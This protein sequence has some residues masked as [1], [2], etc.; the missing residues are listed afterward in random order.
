MVGVVGAS[1]LSGMQRLWD[2][3]GWREMVAGG[4]LE[5]PQGPPVP[6]SP[7]ATGVRCAEA[8]CRGSL[9]Q[10]SHVCLL[11]QPAAPQQRAAG[12]GGLEAPACLFVLPVC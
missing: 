1:H 6:E 5:A 2:S 10:G 3:G 12:W 4:L 9:G 8:A 7:D 11:A